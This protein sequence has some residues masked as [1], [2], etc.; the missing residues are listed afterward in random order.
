MFAKP[1]II[2]CRPSASTSGA[3]AARCRS[4]TTPTT[5][6]AMLNFAF[7]EDSLR[8]DAFNA[9]FAPADADLSRAARRVGRPPDGRGVREDAAERHAVAARRRPSADREP[10]AD[11]ERRRSRFWGSTIEARAC[12]HRGSRSRFGAR[13]VRRSQSA[14]ARFRAAGSRRRLGRS[15]ARL[16]STLRVGIRASPAAATR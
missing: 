5:P 10:A 8:Y 3:A 16:P 6:S 7:Y 13:R 12:A 1:G 14:R 15:S 2:C 11:L 4:S 9:A